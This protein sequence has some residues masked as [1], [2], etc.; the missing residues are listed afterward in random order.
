[1]VV[2]QVVVATAVGMGALCRLLL[3]LLLL[4]VV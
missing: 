4:L 2:G 3:L 1:M